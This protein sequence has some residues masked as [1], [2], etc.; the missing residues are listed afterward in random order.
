MPPLLF[1]IGVA[2]CG[3]T[4]I[5][6]AVAS[7]LGYAFID[8]DDLHPPENVAKM[9]G[10]TPLTDADRWPWLTAVARAAVDGSGAGMVCACSALRRSY[11]D[12]LIAEAG[13]PIRYVL[14]HGPRALLLD[15][16]NQRFGHFMKPEM[17][18]S[19]L[20]TLELPEPD[21]DVTVVD[22]TGT[23]T[24]ITDRVLEALGKAEA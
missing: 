22:I 24:D 10:G 17:L 9:A 3:K 7:R 5:G 23:V 1:V 4:T 14:L 13:Q 21:E 15:R 8:A 12:H 20:A 18:D 11:R 16:L 2:G 6:R 19:Q